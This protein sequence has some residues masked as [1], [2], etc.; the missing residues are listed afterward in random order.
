MYHKSCIW[1]WFGCYILVIDVIYLP[2]FSRVYFLV[3]GKYL[4]VFRGVNYV[5][6]KDMDNIDRHVSHQVSVWYDRSTRT[7]PL[8]CADISCERYIALGMNY[9]YPHYPLHPPP[10]LLGNARLLKYK[11]N[12]ILAETSIITIAIDETKLI[13]QRSIPILA[14]VAM[15][16]F[17]LTWA[18][19]VLRRIFCYC[20]IAV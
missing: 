14:F 2:I 6:L 4:Y 12:A 10:R 7:N 11:R 18:M 5:I 1:V 17:C 20:T 3:L 9:R 16:F 8:R 15:Q 13:F 19:I